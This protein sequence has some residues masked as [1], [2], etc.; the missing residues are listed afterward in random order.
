MTS[1]QPSGASLPTKVRSFHFPAGL[2]LALGALLCA[3]C[4]SLPLL[5]AIGI[6]GAALTALG[7]PAETIGIALI[8]LGGLGLIWRAVRRRRSAR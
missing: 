6:G 3:L 5:A 8:L 7:G 1:R 2:V 4:C